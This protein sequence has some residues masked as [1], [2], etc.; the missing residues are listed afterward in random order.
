MTDDFGASFLYDLSAL[1]AIIF[2]DF[3]QQFLKIELLFCRFEIGP[4]RNLSIGAY[5]QG[6]CFRVVGRMDHVVHDPTSA[7][8]TMDW[9]HCRLTVFEFLLKAP[10]NHFC[11]GV[12]FHAKQFVP[13]GATPPAINLPLGF[14]PTDGS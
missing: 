7:A 10:R 1:C 13:I 11:A 2:L 12:S 4:A 14:S 3:S 5:H 9:V 6:K 8:L